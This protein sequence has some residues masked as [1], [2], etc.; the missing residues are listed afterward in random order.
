MASRGGCAIVDRRVRVMRCAHG[1]SGDGRARGI[2]KSEERQ[3]VDP[4]GGGARDPRFARQPDRR[5][6]RAA[7]RR[8]ARTGDGSVGGLDRRARGARAAGQAAQALRRQGRAQGGRPREQ[9]HRAEP[10]RDR[11]GQP[12]VHRRRVDR[13]GRHA[14]QVEAGRERDARRLDGR[15][16]R[17]G[18]VARSSALSLPGRLQHEGPARP[19]AERAQRRGARGQQRRLAGASPRPSVAASSATTRSRPC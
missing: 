4:R 8:R 17:R 18:G 3:R 7:R 16:P 1:V 5:G 10:G 14:E 13:D 2:E 15:G 19:D 11:G 12:G 6:R 9:G